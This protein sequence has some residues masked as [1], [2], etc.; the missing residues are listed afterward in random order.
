MSKTLPLRKSTL[1]YSPL[2][3][4]TSS[5]S[6]WLKLKKVD[7]LCG[8][9]KVTLDQ[10]THCLLALTRQRHGRPGGTLPTATTKDI[11]S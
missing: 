8:Q 10:M 2:S 5:L 6:Q 11:S 9:A 4:G 7:M 1:P 3:P